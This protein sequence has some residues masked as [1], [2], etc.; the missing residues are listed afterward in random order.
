M[1]PP[2]LPPRKR[3]PL[4]KKEDA[5]KKRPPYTPNRPPKPTVPCTRCDPRD[6]T[7]EAEK[8]G[9]KFRVTCPDCNGTGTRPA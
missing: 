9:H 7:I 1:S 4:Q 5:K 2:K 6:H 3:N 8:D